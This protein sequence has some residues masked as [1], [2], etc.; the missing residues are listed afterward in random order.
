MKTNDNL[1]SNEV[2]NI[3]SN[4]GSMVKNFDFHEKDW[5]KKKRKI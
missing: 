3:I 5:D 1:V 2:N 4:F